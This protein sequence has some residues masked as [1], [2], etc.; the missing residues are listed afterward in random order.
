MR[1]SEHLKA[2]RGMLWDAV[3][4]RVLRHGFRGRRAHGDWEFRTRHDFGTAYFFVFFVRHQD[5]FDLTLFVAL[6]YDAVEEIA[7]RQSTWLSEKEKKRTVT[8][9]NDLGYLTLGEPVRRTVACEADIEPVAAQ[10]EGQLVDIALP[11]IQKMGDMSNAYKAIASLAPEDAVH[12]LA[13]YARANAAV[14]MALLLKKGEQEVSELVD[15]HRAFLTRRNDIGLPRF[16]QLVKSL[17][18]S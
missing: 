15:R 6:R 9:G 13:D 4:E 1:D 5:D 7:Q 17:G 3:S 8:L 14:V 18:L 2:L 10:I 11:Y 16:E 12:C